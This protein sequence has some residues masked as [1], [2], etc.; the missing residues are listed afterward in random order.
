MT[1]HKVL[2]LTQTAVIFFCIHSL[3]AQSPFDTDLNRQF[4]VLGSEATG[5]QK[6]AASD[7]VEFLLSSFLNQP[8]S[9]A[10]K[11]QVEHLGKIAA[12]DGKL[13]VYSWNYQGD[14]LLYH[15][16]CIIQHKTDNGIQLTVLKDTRNDIPVN[17]VLK[18]DEW[19]GCLYYAVIVKTKRKKTYYTLLGWDGHNNVVAR[20]VID[21]LLFKPNNEPVLGASV[22]K[23]DR[24]TQKRVVF[25]FSGTGSM[26][27][28]YDPDY[29]RIIFDHLS[30]AK[31]E[32]E[33]QYQY[34]G[35]DFSYDGFKFRRGKWE[36]EEML[37]PRNKND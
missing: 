31:P 21:V 8:Q 6:K 20:K 12:S 14:D 26:V 10:V 37:D 19:Y 5:V 27:L 1:F 16:G 3:F 23:M 18:P 33:G 29:K 11:P 35:S 32:L 9:F 25:N 36:F 13:N 7:S 4:K 34:Y 2:R 30:P 28:V 24:G 17:E 15:Y 22:F